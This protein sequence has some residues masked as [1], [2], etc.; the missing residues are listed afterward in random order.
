V[1]GLVEPRR[2][3]DLSKSKLVSLPVTLNLVHL[4]TRADRLNGNL[5][6]YTLLPY[7]PP[8]PGRVPLCG[9]R[10]RKACYLDPRYPRHVRRR[11]TWAEYR[12]FF[13]RSYLTGRERFDG[14]MPRLSRPT[15]ASGEH[16]ADTAGRGN[17]PCGV[18]NRR[19]AP[20]QGLGLVVN[21][22]FTYASHPPPS[23]QSVQSSASGRTIASVGLH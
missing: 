10:L 14:A 4:T 11:L 15:L 7:Q 20:V 1:S 22:E 13:E 23:Y 6:G 17:R 16:G 21:G 3:P 19:G 8:T 18:G 5:C 2:A 12:C 9:Y